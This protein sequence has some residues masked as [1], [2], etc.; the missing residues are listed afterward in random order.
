[1]TENAGSVALTL[2]D[3]RLRRDEILALADRYG[4]YNVRVFGSVARGDATCES[5]I[6]L[7]VDF[8]DG[9]SLYDVAGLWLSLQELL[10]RSVDLADTATPKKHFLQRALKDAVPL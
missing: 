9:S 6:D 7:L 5:D 8:R 10:N 3:L 4:A 2:A 1:V